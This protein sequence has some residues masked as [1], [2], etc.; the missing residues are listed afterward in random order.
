V[1]KMFQDDPE[2]EAVVLIGGL[3]LARNSCGVHQDNST[4]PLPRR[5]GRLAPR[6][7][8]WDR[9]RLS[10]DQGAQG[11]SGLTEAGGPWLII[12]PRLEPPRGG[13]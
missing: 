3:G 6:A 9:K 11:R 2:T 7:S 12:S 13:A 8:A 4:S 10:A 5:A 1:L